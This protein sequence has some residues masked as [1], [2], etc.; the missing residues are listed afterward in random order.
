MNL[1]KIMKQLFHYLSNSQQRM[2][3]NQLMCCGTSINGHVYTTDE[4]LH[5]K[6]IMTKNDTSMRSKSLNNG[7]KI[8][9]E[10]VRYMEVPMHLY[11]F[12]TWNRQIILTADWF[13]SIL[14]S[15]LLANIHTI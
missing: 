13:L 4:H 11:C 9:L 3:V 10:G 14:Q 1:L 12:V 2:S 5:S 8:G 15:L 7:Q 6:Y